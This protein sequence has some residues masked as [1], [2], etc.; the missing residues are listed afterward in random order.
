MREGRRPLAVLLAVLL[1]VAVVL[2]GLF[3]APQIA[4]PGRT[5][6]WIGQWLTGYRVA[7]RGA[8]TVSFVGGL[9]IEAED[10]VVDLP[11]DRFLPADSPP[12]ARIARVEARIDLLPLLVGLVRIERLVLSRPSLRFDRDSE[13]RNN[14]NLADKPRLGGGPPEAAARKPARPG[15]FFRFAVTSAR[16]SGGTLRYTDGRLDRDVVVDGLGAEAVIDRGLK[17]ETLRLR[18]DGSHKGEPVY[19]EG[20]LQRLE[21]YRDGIRVPF[22]V[23][24]DAAPGQVTLRGSVARRRYPAVS[25][26]VSVEMDDLEAVREVWPTL[27]EELAGRVAARLQVESRGG[28]TAVDI[29]TLVLGKTDL[30]GKVRLDLAAKLPTADVSLDAGVLDHR[31]LFALARLAGLTPGT[32]GLAS[33]FAL[34]GQGRLTWAR[35]SSLPGVGAGAGTGA[36]AVSFSWRTGEPNLAVGAKSLPL[37]GGTIGGRAEVTLAERKLALSLNLVASDLDVATLFESV[38]GG[39]GMDGKAHGNLEVLAVGG[40]VDELLRAAGGGGRLVISDGHIVGS[41][42]QDLL[43]D[44]ERSLGFQRA[45]MDF[46]IAGGIAASDELLL[47]LDIGHA[48]ARVDWDVAADHLR[49]RFARLPVLEERKQPLEVAG[50]PAEVLLSR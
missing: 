15:S 44:K 12:L 14:W 27:P 45:A 34:A 36:G 30:A 19:L 49:F 37:F 1:L 13:G 24:F 50:T 11:A 17:G 21:D 2:G 35:L 40:D 10:I 43:N 16:L 7:V 25:A 41:P 8:A 23:I 31:Q 46:R 4:G 20:E 47:D 28:E 6:A 38:L 18:V 29:Q 32:D 5:V 42:L 22:R 26:D 33:R 48:R 39:K 9:R 3:V